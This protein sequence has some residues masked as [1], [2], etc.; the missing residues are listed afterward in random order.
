MER[1]QIFHGLAALLLLPH[2][3]GCGGG[4]NLKSLNEIMA[5]GSDLTVIAPEEIDLATS[6]LDGIYVTDEPLSYN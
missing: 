2:L 6:D 3:P 1:R 5:E 4:S